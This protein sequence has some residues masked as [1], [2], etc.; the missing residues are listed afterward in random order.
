M[1]RET[2]MLSWLECF[3]SHMGVCMYIHM[4]CQ[5]S[6][7][8]HLKSVNVIVWNTLMKSLKN[9]G[10]IHFQINKNWGTVAS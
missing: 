3:I 10:K 5:K 9:K 7:T 6:S 2:E 1:S 4:I 8:V